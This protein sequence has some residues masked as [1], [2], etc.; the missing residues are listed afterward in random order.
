MLRAR[1]VMRTGSAVGLMLLALAA[2][3]PAALPIGRPVTSE[4]SWAL[5]AIGTI[6]RVKVENRAYTVNGKEF[7]SGG[8]ADVAYGFTHNAEAFLR[9]GTTAEKYEPNPGTSQKLGTQ[10]NWGV[11]LRGTLYD[12]YQ[13][14]KLLGDAQYGGR[15]S[16]GVPGA[17][18]SI[19]DWQIASAVEMEAGNFYP[20]L[21]VLYGRMELKSNNNSVFPSLKSR[22]QFDVYF[23]TGWQPSDLWKTFI[24]ARFLSGFCASAGVSR[25]F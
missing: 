21:G 23:G 13:G 1:S 5:G 18:V 20:Y 24:E 12:S 10:L 15:T 17:E 2:A 16:R 3:A 9:L 6:D 11:G 22:D 4:H 8:Y 19:N 25:A 14:W 7:S